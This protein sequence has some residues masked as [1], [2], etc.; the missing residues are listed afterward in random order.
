MFFIGNMLFIQSEPVSLQCVPG[1][2][3]LLEGL[4][5]L[6]RRAQRELAP[7]PAAVRRG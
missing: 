5:S 3:Q 7:G 6:G 4:S 1:F 2:I